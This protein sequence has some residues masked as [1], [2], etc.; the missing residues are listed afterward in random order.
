MPNRKESDAFVVR[1]LD[2]ELWRLRGA[3]LAGIVLC[4]AVL[5]LCLTS[6][7]SG[8]GILV[9]WLACVAMPLAAPATAQGAT[10]PLV[11]AISGVQP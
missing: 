10:S 9:R 2:R 1:F 5:W 3:C 11:V 8:A 6:E 7:T 4:P